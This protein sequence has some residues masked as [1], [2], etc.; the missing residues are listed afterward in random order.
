MPLDNDVGFWK[1]LAGGI[2]GV[3]SG[4][5]GYHRY[6]DAKIAKKA[7]KLDVDDK[8][9]EVRTELI[10]QRDNQGKLFDYLRDSDQRAQDRHER[11]LER[12]K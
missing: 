2:V 11:L 3:V 1:W 8:F 6:I 9:E 7:D 10:R 4:G 5:F 12:M